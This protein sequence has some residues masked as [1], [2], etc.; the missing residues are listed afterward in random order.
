M[1]Q[2]YLLLVLGALTVSTAIAAPSIANL[3]TIQVTHLQDYQ[4][5]GV[6][7]NY[8]SSVEHTLCVRNTGNS[9]YQ[10]TVTSAEMMATGNQT[11]FAMSSGRSK[12]P[13]HVFWSDS[14]KSHI[15][16]E[17][18]PG[19]PSPPMQN[20]SALVECGDNDNASLEI[21]LLSKEMQGI[22]AGQYTTN[23]EITVAPI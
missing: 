18:Q 14:V 2:R 6:D 10:V 15:Y 12:L 8:D 23:L 3:A 9:S 21:K 19:V 4:F 11:K 13:Y 5:D 20:A 1:L 17:L 7:L 16:T 22:T